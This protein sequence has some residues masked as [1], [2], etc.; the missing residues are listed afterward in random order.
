[1]P[2][3]PGGGADHGLAAARQGVGMLARDEVDEL[4]AHIATVL[5][6]FFLVL[7]TVIFLQ[8]R[9]MRDRRPAAGQPR[10]ELA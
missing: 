2:V 5:V 1:M 7:H 6:P 3:I 8:L 10:G 4:L 9:A